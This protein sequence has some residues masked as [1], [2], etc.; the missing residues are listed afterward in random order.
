MLLTT[1]LISL[2]FSTAFDTIDHTIL[3]SHLQTSFDITGLALAW[4]HSYL[5]GRRQ[6][7]RIGCSASPVTLC[8]TGVQQGSVLGLMLFCLFISPI[9]NIVSSYGLLK[10]YADDT[11]FY[12]AISKVNYDTPVCQT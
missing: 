6:F 10:Q 9:A 2:N 11:Q 1:V 8:T 7:V 3:L 5:E 12:V 4:F